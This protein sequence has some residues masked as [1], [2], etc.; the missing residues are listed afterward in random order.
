MP[1]GMLH[2]AGF[3]VLVIDLRDFGLS[4]REDGHWAGGIDE[5]GGVTRAWR[6]L[7]ARATTQ[8]PSG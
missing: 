1:A 2:R 7:R 3:G 4:D 5:Y 6:W 8:A